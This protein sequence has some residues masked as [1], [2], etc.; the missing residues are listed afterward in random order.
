MVI[1][2][3]INSPPPPDDSCCLNCG[4]ALSGPYCNSCGQRQL[5]LDQPIRDLLREVVDSFLSL[6]A[7]IIRTLWALISRPGW[8]TTEFLAGR[9]VRYVHPFK[10]YFA[11]SLLL[12]LALALTGYSSVRVGSKE[13]K[14][15]AGLHIDTSSDEAEADSDPATSRYSLRVWWVA[16]SSSPIRRL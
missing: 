2:V 7:R 9:R 8:L 13:D 1:V 11:F 5:D 3:I 16:S 12:F 14:V 4:T 10:L 6:D 15:V